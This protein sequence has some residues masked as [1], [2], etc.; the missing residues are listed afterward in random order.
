MF[1]NLLYHSQNIIGYI[2]ERISYK[3]E[4]PYLP[5]HAPGAAY[6]FRHSLLERKS[7]M[8]RFGRLEHR[9]RGDYHKA[10][11][12]GGGIAR[13]ETVTLVSA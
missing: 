1:T 6:D 2:S 11:E 4:A 8:S 13:A 5:N 3:G 7:V 9:A 12:Y 10:D